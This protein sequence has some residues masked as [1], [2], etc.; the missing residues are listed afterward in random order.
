M[1]K[2][3]MDSLRGTRRSDINNELIPFKDHKILLE[4][5]TFLQDTIFTRELDVDEFICPLYDKEK[6]FFNG[7]CTTQLCES[8]AVN[9]GCPK[10]K[11]CVEYLK[12]K[13]LQSIFPDLDWEKTYEFNPVMK[14]KIKEKKA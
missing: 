3:P 7:K 8:L 11:T 9:R 12:Q 14:E 13:E 1:I 5:V 10:M 4:Y 2:M 6:E